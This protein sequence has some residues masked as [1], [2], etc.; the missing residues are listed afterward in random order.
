MELIDIYKRVVQEMDFAGLEV[1]FH[2]AYSGRGMYGK[3]TVGISG[4]DFS[5]DDLHEFFLYIIAEE[6]DNEN[7]DNEP[8]SYCGAVDD[9]LSRL[10]EVFPT[11]KDSMGLGT[12]FY[13]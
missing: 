4:E 2:E 13:K 1:S 10:K 6:L 7:A 5:E 3:T 8:I 11:K 9:L 12:I